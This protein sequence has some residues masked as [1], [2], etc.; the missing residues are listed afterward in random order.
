MAA[1]DSLPLQALL[2][3]G[4]LTP[5]VLSRLWVHSTGMGQVHATE[6]VEIQNVDH[7]VIISNELGRRV[8]KHQNDSWLL[9]PDC[10]LDSLRLT[11]AF[12]N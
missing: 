12:N 4:R 6:I 10:E 7:E 1:A 11:R 5:R 3:H 8:M 2:L 9:R